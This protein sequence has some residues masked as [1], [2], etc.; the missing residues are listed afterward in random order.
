MLEKIISQWYYCGEIHITF[1]NDHGKK[2]YAGGT[3][4]LTAKINAAS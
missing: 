4:G 2:R 3:A 1:H